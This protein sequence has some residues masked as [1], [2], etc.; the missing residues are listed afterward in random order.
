MKFS[1]SLLVASAFASSVFALVPSKPTRDIWVLNEV[2]SDI[3]DLN[4][5]VTAYTGGTGTTVISRADTLIGTLNAGVTTAN[6]Q[7]M[8]TLSESLALQGPVQTVTGSTRDLVDDLTAKRPL[9]I[10]NGLCA[11]TRGRVNTINTSANNLINA[12]VAK[13]PAAAQSIAERLVSDLRAELA[14]AKTNFSTSNCP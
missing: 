10:S 9:I 3:I 12:I 6:A 4:N 7:P 8:L 2:N 11:T 5:A 14:R 1:A 13:V